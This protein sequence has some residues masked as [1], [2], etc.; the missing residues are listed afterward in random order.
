M[1]AG[2]VVNFAVG[3]RPNRGIC[4]ARGSVARLA[5][6]WSPLLVQLAADRPALGA[7][8][9]PGPAWRQGYTGDGLASTIWPECAGCP[10]STHSK[11]LAATVTCCEIA[12]SSAIRPPFAGRPASD[13]AAA[14]RAYRW[15]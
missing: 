11:V 4:P 14:G 13:P 9:A 7:D 10:A 12:G 3:G 5:R 6:A 8:R 15:S 2:L 1:D